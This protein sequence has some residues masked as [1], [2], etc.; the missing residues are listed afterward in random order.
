MRIIRKTKFEISEKNNVKTYFETEFKETQIGKIPKDWEVREIGDIAKFQYGLGES[1][2]KNGKIIYLRITDIN[3]DGTLNKNNLQ[4]ISLENKDYFLEK[5]DI[6]VARIGATFGKMYEF[7]E[8]F[9]ATFGGFLIRFIFY[10]LN[11]DSIGNKQT[12]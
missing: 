11:L 2:K 6:L 3:E 1:A 8:K 12:I 7:K 10:F 4:Y 9:R 5:G